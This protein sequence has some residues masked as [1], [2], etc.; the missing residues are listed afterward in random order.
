M[1]DIVR[2][3]KRLGLVAHDSKKDDLVEWAVL[4][5]HELVRH[6]PFA[7]GPTGTILE[8][9]LGV[10]IIKLQSGPL[11]GDPPDRRPHR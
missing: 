4:K 9:A 10:G 2:V 11:G 7:T 5:R 1:N 8:S 3:R 6:D